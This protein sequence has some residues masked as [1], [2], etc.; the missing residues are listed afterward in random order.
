MLAGMQG[1]GRRCSSAGVTLSPSGPAGE[2]CDGG[3]MRSLN[4]EAESSNESVQTLGH[5]LPDGACTLDHNKT[6]IWHVPAKR[7]A[8]HL[9]QLA[10]HR[11][12]VAAEQAQRARQAQRVL[13]AQ[14][15]PSAHVSWPCRQMVVGSRGVGH[16]V[17]RGVQWTCSSPAPAMN[18]AHVCA[19]QSRLPQP[20]WCCRLHPAP[21]SCSQMPAGL[22]VDRLSG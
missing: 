5:G 13:E 14:R 15:G 19:S 9:E 20:A 4:T 6:P 2:W 8:T 1:T 11:Q 17:V 22:G 7:Y 3:K 12:V 16:F 21:T 10:G 18:L